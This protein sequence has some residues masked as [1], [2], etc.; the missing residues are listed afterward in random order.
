MYHVFFLKAAVIFIL[1]IYLFCL[2]AISWAAPAAYA[3]S[4]A[5]GPIGAVATSLCQSHSNAG[6]KPRLQPTPQ[7]MAM[8]DRQPTEQGQGQNPHPH[9]S[10]SASLTT[11]PRREL[12]YH[13]F[14]IHSSVDGHLGCFHVLA[15]ANSAA[16]NIGVHVSLQ[17]MV[18]S[19]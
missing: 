19:G 10:Q 12:L 6:S 1:F 5:R 3:G 16:M 9:G 17:V 13:I 18:F 14:L 7:L 15:I 2:F 11:A 8:P 4:H